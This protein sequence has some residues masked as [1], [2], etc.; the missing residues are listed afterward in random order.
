[1]AYESALDR[2]NRVM[3]AKQ[4][5]RT[6]YSQPTSAVTSY[7]LG[8]TTSKEKEKNKG[9]LL[10][11]I[12]YVGEKLG[13]GILRSVEGISDFVLGGVA[14]LFGADDFAD[15]LLKS[16]WVDYTHADNWYNP[17][18]V[19]SFVGDVS[20]GIGGM[21]PAVALSFVP[22][23]GPAL[24]HVAF[25]LGAA[26]QSVSDMTKQ[27]GTASGKEWL[28]GIGSGLLE[29]GIEAATAGFGGSQMGKVLGKQLAKT[30][31]G[32]LATAFVSEG[33][34]EVASDLLDPALQ[35]T[36]GVNKEATVDWKNLPK[37]FL[38]GGATG[39]VMGGGYRALNA[40]KVGGF[41]N[42]AVAETAQELN[43]RLSD[44]NVRQ[45]KNKKAT[46]TAKDIGEV[47]ERLSK[48]L[49]KL[50]D[51]GRANFFKENNR[52]AKYFN[53]D[54]TLTSE[55]WE[56]ARRAPARFSIETD[57]K[58]R[59]YVQADRK[60]LSGTNAKAWGEQI[61]EYI[62]EKI[63]NGE[64]I[65]I[66]TVEGDTLTI[67]ENTAGKAAF[68]NKGLDQ[69]GYKTKLQ[70][71][72]HID[73]LSQI[74]K[75]QKDQYG[76]KK[77]KT[78]IENKHVKRNLAKDG[79]SYRN[80]YF[81]DFDGNEYK[82]TL[83][84]AMDGTVESVY[85]VGKIEKHRPGESRL[86]PQR[87]AD[88]SINSIREK[89]EN[90]NSLEE[91]SAKTNSARYSIK[92]IDGKDI[93]SIDTDQN[94][95]DGVERKDYGKVAREYIKSHFRGKRVNDVAFTKYSE[96][97]YIRSK[98]TQRLYGSDSS[99]YDTKM[100]AS[101]ELDNFVKTGKF[102]QHEEA[103][104]PHPYNEGGYDRYAVEFALGG[105]SFTGEM[106]VA[107]NNENK[108]MFYDIVNIKEKN[109]LRYPDAPLKGS[110]G[111]KNVLSTNSI[112][113]KNENVNSLEEKNSK[114]NSQTIGN[115]SEATYSASLK[116]RES[117]L[118][119][120]PV[121]S[122][123][124]QNENARR[125]MRDITLIT[126]G[127]VDVVLTE[128]IRTADGR[129]A[130]G[131][132][133]DGV[134]YV[135]V[136]ADSSNRAM[137]IISHELTHTLEGTKEYAALGS[138]IQAQIALDPALAEKYNLKKYL[139]AYKGAHKGEYSEE[140][141]KY[142]ARTE[143]YADFVADE[144]LSNESTVRRLVSRNRNIAL[145]FVEWVRST[146]ERLGKSKEERAEYDLLRRAEKLFVK[147]LENSKGGVTL[148]EVEK[149]AQVLK[150]MKKTA[151]TI[152]ENTT[153][154][155]S[156]EVATISGRYN[157]QESIKT[158]QG[159]TEEEIASIQKNRKYFVA[160]SYNDVIA[161]LDS[162]E[163]GENKNCLLFIGKVSDK[164]SSY[165]QDE[166][167]I[168]IKG[169][170]IALS[171]DNIRHILVKHGEE[172]KEG[173]RGQ[174][175]IT[176][177]KLEDII[178]TI[179]E[180]DSVSKEVDDSGKVSILFEKVLNGRNLAIT[181]LSNK[182]NALTLKSARV[183]KNSISPSND[184]KASRSTSK[185]IGSMDDSSTISIREGNEKVNSFD[186]KSLKKDLERYSINVKIPHT[187][188]SEARHAG[189]AEELS[190]YTHRIN[191]TD[192][193]KADVRKKF[194]R[195]RAERMFAV[196][197]NTT[198]RTD[199]VDIPTA[200]KELTEKGFKTYSVYYED[201][202][203]EMDS[204]LRHADRKTYRKAEK[205]VDVA[206][207]I[208]TSKNENEAAKPKDEELTNRQIQTLANW[209]NKK[210]YSKSEAEIIINDILD[211]Y[212]NF[213]DTVGNLSGK[214]QEEAVRMLWRGMNGSNRT[215]TAR[216]VANYLL[217]HAILENI[218]GDAL[219][220]SYSQTIDILR[221]YLHKLDLTDI[222]EGLKE[223]YGDDLSYTRW[224]KA[225][226]DTGIRIEDAADAL[227]EAGFYIEE[228]TAMDA[229]L[230]IEKAYQQAI[231]NIKKNTSRIAEEIVGKNKKAFQQEM[232]KELLR[233]F[234]AHGQDSALAMIEN[235]Y[236]KQI[237]SWKKKVDETREKNRVINRILEKAQK[238]K[239]VKTG[240]FINASVFKR[241]IFK[242][243]IECLGKIKHR[244]DLNRSGTRKIFAS[245]LEWYSKD[246]PMLEGDGYVQ[247]VADALMR[248][249]DNKA[250]MSER[251]YEELSRLE[252][253][254]GESDV[255]KIAEWYTRK[256]LGSE[257]DS[258]VKE[259]LKDLANPKNFSLQELKDM[260]MVL[261]Y[262]EHTIKNYNKIFRNGKRID[263]IP[264]AEKGIANNQ[265]NARVK[266]G[267]LRKFFEGFIV[268]YADPMTVARY[269][270]KYARGFYTE[271]MEEFREAAVEAEV[272]EMRLRDPLENFY[273]K[274]KN[275]LKESEKREIIYRGKSMNVQTAM[276]LHMTLKRD[277]ALKGLAYSG[278]KYNKT[279]EYIESVQGFATA[280]NLEWEELKLQAEAEQNELVKQFT[281]TELE[282]IAI[283]EKIFNE[284]C[285]SSKKKTD[286]E[287]MGFSNVSDGYYV[288]IRR[289]SIAYNIGKQGYAD[290]MMA[291]TN[292][293]FNE[294][295]VA[296]AEN[297]LF[298]D[299]LTH[300]AEKH[301][302]GISQYV[303]TLRLS[304][305][306]K[307]MLMGYLGYSNKSGEEK[308]K[309]YI[310]HLNL[311]KEQKQ[312]L[313]EY[314]GY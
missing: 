222:K 260:K 6:S 96:N 147:A 198:E 195:E 16:D 51:E 90:V 13:L 314:C 93:V 223:R 110:E 123:S 143:M 235:D 187:Q 101:T 107:K 306:K 112:R 98:E 166:I 190:Q 79:W 270:D 26:G 293:S 216:D 104:H 146:V 297:Q 218:Y 249:A 4:Y 295:T 214:T 268:S 134:L 56:S 94:I 87:A 203:G 246:N 273:K 180:P 237:R 262:F 186:E 174:V 73:E 10:G 311:T 299:G 171:S 32:K 66:K 92:N 182:K 19:M 125:A 208:S 234:D 77:I 228:A 136:N 256:N 81:K 70:A 156:S 40:A 3:E 215:K 149:T 189:Y 14:D 131:E 283:V 154:E 57:E 217:E 242:G 119:Y 294:N 127:R 313:Y 210:V 91:K 135:N 121:T 39:S 287:R 84:V 85:N 213:E 304:A 289:T 197:E 62:N 250:P 129:I 173:K 157:L 141:L 179:V 117:T 259:W 102:I 224:E 100:K 290:E 225:E 122:A 263:A 307:H 113:E 240:A 161:F 169:K 238:I 183:F 2:Y 212:M 1:M 226:G 164:M 205:G 30:T 106:L 177:E 199:G 162:A 76:N 22:V 71:E 265:K 12:G 67:T 29:T 45:A 202:L 192:E 50:D 128:D 288:P 120:Q 140:T 99:V 168:D 221:P 21:L 286:I 244:G 9:G 285:K 230:A 86:M 148:E 276:L 170:S 130:N 310:N 28:Y 291:V 109:T 41:K 305:E 188:E 132:Y 278:F 142:E 53:A 158:L 219:V 194:G 274:H 78:D 5:G 63:R 118:K 302:E 309:A 11:G 167:N 111:G 55:A 281:E 253:E 251:Q 34:E 178:E 252:R 74:S 181:I 211:T 200:H 138:F 233:E 114:T 108:T 61:T 97:E 75:A 241:D 220:E 24:S 300:V 60:V 229:F 126:G 48:R 277:H 31:G 72:A 255:K 175:V 52:L 23:A 261:D 269:F 275:F 58:G 272:M 25:G 298:I 258:E 8:E 160:N 18:G 184:A 49:Q 44:N 204:T 37:T 301:I 38:V 308:V 159:Y 17:D 243:S 254:S 176:K 105:E 191:L 172:I 247:D 209:K 59:Q 248:I 36:T 82:L 42:L 103:K 145:R 284:D 7:N 236:K 144:I 163:K 47:Q 165:I 206:L 46:Y 152:E 279:E 267:W 88:V 292:Q 115:L 155:S 65:K 80:A 43:E 124:A 20:Q 193:I 95:F 271:S 139:E 264:I 54:G 35:R 245:L 303:N 257:W 133:A 266:I 280:E 282:Y 207:D 239:D 137:F 15:E 196:W 150:D 89:N 153:D 68:Q 185:T 227:R 231:D 296:G 116:G 69:E 201:F 27:N 151:Q 83:S 232:A 33:L 312:K 64:D